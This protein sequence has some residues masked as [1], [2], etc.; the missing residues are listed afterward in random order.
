MSPAPNF[1]ETISV[2]M[3]VTMRSPHLRVPHQLGELDIAHLPRVLGAKGVPVGV[4]DDLLSSPRLD[5]RPL[6]EAIHLVDETVLRVW[7]PPL[8]QK[9]V[10]GWLVCFGATASRLRPGIV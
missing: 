5:T 8:V 2:E 3:D 9:H 6:P 4:K 10:I 7:A 1:V